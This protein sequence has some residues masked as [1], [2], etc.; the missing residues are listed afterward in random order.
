MKIRG[1][2]LLNNFYAINTD[3]I[4][5]DSSRNVIISDLEAQVR[6]LKG[7]VARRESAIFHAY[8]VDTHSLKC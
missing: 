3:G 6:M 4:D 5:P 1:I 7:Q 2:N 8:R